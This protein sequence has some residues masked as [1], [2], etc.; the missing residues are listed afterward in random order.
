MHTEIVFSLCL[1]NEVDI[2]PFLRD[3]KREHPEIECRM[4]SSQGT[5]QIVLRSD[6]PLDAVALTFEEKFPTYVFHEKT[7][8]EAVHLALIGAKKT[9]GLAESCTG[10]ALA[11]RLTAL[12]DASYYLRGSIV[13]YSNAWK[14]RFLLVSPQTLTKHGAVSRETVEE[15]IQ[16]I[17]SQ[18]DVDYAIGVSGIAGP[19]G[20]TPQTPVGTI[21]IGIGRRGERSDIGLIHAEKD[22]ARAIDRAVQTS[23]C[24]LWRRI[25]HNTPTFT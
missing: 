8:E 1:F 24:A 14:E 16:G 2:A 11:A 7:I 23:L 19:S 21:C 18:T 9:L 17:F 10:G 20:G 22:R 15:M 5:L 13:A 4:S 3:L 12:P 25:V 6:H